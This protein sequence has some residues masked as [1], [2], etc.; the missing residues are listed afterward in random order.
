MTARLEIL[1]EDGEWREVEGVASFEFCQ[2]QPEDGA[3]DAYW[4]RLW[5]ETVDVSTSTELV[6]TPD[7]TPAERAGQVMRLFMASAR[8][9]AVAY[10]QACALF[11]QQLKNSAAAAKAYEAAVRPRQDRPAWQSPYGPARRRR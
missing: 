10:E 2:E 4:A 8:E 6:L 1:G 5:D 3:G 7:V 9:A 11:V